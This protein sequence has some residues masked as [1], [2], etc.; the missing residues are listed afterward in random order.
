M[1]K[2][3]ILMSVLTLASSC[4]IN[5]DQTKGKKILIYTRNGTGFVHD[6][7]E[8][9]VQ[10]LEEICAGLG[11]ETE[12]TDSPEVFTSDRLTGFDGIVFSN[13]NNEAFTSEDQREAFQAFIRSGKGF[14]GIHSST[15][16][17][18]DWPWF[19]AM[20]G[21]TFLRHPPLQ[22]FDIKVI[23]TRH[24]S[25]A[26]LPPVWKW[27]DECYYIHHLNPDI[28]VLL[29]ADLR[30]VEDELKEEYPGTTFGDYIPLA[31]CH[32]FEGGRQWYTA[33]GHTI[34]YYDDPLFRGHLEGGIRWILGSN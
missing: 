5:Q 27:E 2:L 23:D 15:G 10:A 22:E 3:I 30:T 11:I 20:Q 6:N 24:V 18:R 13:S 17:E 16:S 8:A 21:G 7:I 9:S 34:E 1:K 12:V 14:A 31:W 32:Q 19:W 33:L 26:H 4:S 28:H 29:A 25:T